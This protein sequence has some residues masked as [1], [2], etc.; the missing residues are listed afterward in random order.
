MTTSY[1]H[2]QLE[3]DQDGIVWLTFDRAGQPLNSMSRDVFDELDAIVD[4]FAANPPKGIAVR[5]GK[6][7]GF[8]AGADIT[9]FTQLKTAD[10]AF[11]LIRQAQIVFDKFEALSV[12]TVAMIDG[13]C[14]GGGTEFVLACRY[15]IAT[16][17]VKTR[18]GLPE[19]FLGIHPG[20]GGTVR[21]PLLI[22]APKAMDLMLSGRLIDGR[23]AKKMG[24]VDDCVPEREL[25]RAARYY[26]LE[27]PQPHRLTWKESLTNSNLM[28]PILGKF[29]YAQLK[30][31]HVIKAHYPAPY[32]I[33]RNWIRDGA[34]GNAMIHEAKSI[35]KLMVTPTARNLV[36]AFFLKNALKDNGKQ[37]NFKAKHVHVIG[38]GVM[39]GDI[40]AW[41]ALKGMHVTLQDQ[42][43]ERIAPALGRAYRLYQRKLKLPRLIQG[44]MDRLQPDVTGRGLAR[45]DVIIEAVFEDLTVK[46]AIFKTVESRAKPEAILASNTSSI[47]LEEIASA[48]QD[49]SRL[50]GIHFFN[51]VAKMELVEVIQA[52]QTRPELLQSAASFVAKIARLPL[53]V[54]SAPGFLVNRILMPYLMEAMRLLEEGYSP[55]T[56]DDAAT[57]FGMLMGPI[58]LADTVGLDI[59]YHAGKELTNAFGGSM[60][61]RLKT[62][63]TAGHLGKKTGRG[64]YDYDKKGK[65][66]KPQ[67]SAE[68]MD[69]EVVTDRL[70]L[71]MLNEGV[72]CLDSGVVKTLEDVD[73]GM[74]FGTGFA[75]F[76]GGPMQYAKTRGPA[77]IVKT[78]EILVKRFGE[79]FKPKAGW[80]RLLDSAAEA[81]QKVGPTAAEQASQSTASRLQPEAE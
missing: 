79:R 76:R 53:M 77:E 11:D 52:K 18:I 43:P 29:M 78:L 45:A 65:P 71:P 68:P 22:G 62:M 60:P 54:K 17:S 23:K 75:P 40:A 57:Q 21:L 30:K 4:M 16:E 47:P 9:Q 50:L 72:A 51:P 42:S 38:A 35:A 55:R 64:F 10:E 26:L 44:V 80:T 6:Q 7:T 73:A 3:T 36:R 2:W 61:E 70:I 12:P 31:K 25:K 56:I 15:R 19:V 58:T 41:C 63:V 5:S 8:I 33:V 81:E 32:A 14:L 74:I 69:I 37:S 24:V 27:Q 13:F 59:L 1:T 66:I 49:P 39:G 28:R 20:W 67:D 34:R 48:M 46:Q